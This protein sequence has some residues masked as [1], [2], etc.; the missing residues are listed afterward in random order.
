[1]VAVKTEGLPK[2]V[3]HFDPITWQATHPQHH[4]CVYKLNQEQLKDWGEMATEIRQKINQKA[5][6]HK[7]FAEPKAEVKE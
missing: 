4:L 5:E 6:N 1:M 7:M 2:L 3:T